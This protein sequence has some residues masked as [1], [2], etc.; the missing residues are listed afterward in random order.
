MVWAAVCS[1]ETAVRIG[2]LWR[3]EVSAS[4]VL[5]LVAFLFVGA[6][7]IVFRSWDTVGA[8]VGSFAAEGCEDPQTDKRKTRTR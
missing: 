7:G 8:A 2:T 4:V 5:W 6:I 1:G 3:L